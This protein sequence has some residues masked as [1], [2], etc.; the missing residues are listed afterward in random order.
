MNKNFTMKGVDLSPPLIFR[1][2]FNFDLDKINPIVDELMKDENA[3]TGPPF[4]IGA[5]R[6]T[7]K[8]VQEKQPHFHPD[9]RLFVEWLGVRIRQVMKICLD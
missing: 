7:F 3:H 2:R 9:I 5:S 8:V 6:T 1:D 4:G